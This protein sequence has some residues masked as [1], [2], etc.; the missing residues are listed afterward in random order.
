[1]DSFIFTDVHE[2]ALK[3]AFPTDRLR[4]H[5]PMSAHTSFKIGGPAD[6]FLRVSCAEDIR[7]ALTVCAETDMPLQVI[8]NGTNLLVGDGGLRGLALQEY[9]FYNAIRVTDAGLIAEA[10]ATLSAL[11]AAA[12]RAGFTGLEFASG[13]PGALG[14][15]LSMNAGAYGGEIAHVVE[16]V[17]TM[18][19]DGDLRVLTCEEMRFGYRTSALQTRGLF[20]LTATLKLPRGDIEASRAL[21]R[22][23]TERRR[24]KQPL[25]MPSAGSAFKRPE[26]MYAGDLIERAGLKGARVG[27]AEISMMHANFIV[28]AGGATAAHVTELIETVQRAVQD[29]FGVWLEPEIHRIGEP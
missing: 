9:N 12:M 8:G 7:R 18:D 14:G 23:L 2:R 19:A 16:S 25:H 27:G 4:F 22:E 5:E 21:T 28:N 10:G 13:I 29:K 11:A 1:M 20:A 17:E 26:G 15:A 3:K 24:S 6:A